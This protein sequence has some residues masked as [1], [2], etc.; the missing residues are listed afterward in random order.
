MTDALVSIIDT[1]LTSVDESCEKL[2]LGR[3]PR[4]ASL[5]ERGGR[6]RFCVSGGSALGA[7]AQ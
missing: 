6:A 3:A 2:L 1:A 5:A 4:G 7:V